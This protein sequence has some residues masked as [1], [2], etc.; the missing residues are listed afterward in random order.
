M[1]I[2]KAALQPYQFN[3]IQEFDSRFPGDLKSLFHVLVLIEFVGVMG[4]VADDDLAAFF[5]GDP[6]EARICIVPMASDAVQVEFHGHAKLF[7]AST[8]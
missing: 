4:V 7:R 2:L 3:R 8:A 5:C 6:E 1:F